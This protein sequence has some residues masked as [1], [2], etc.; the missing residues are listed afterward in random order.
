MEN[1]YYLIMC[2][3]NAAPECNQLYHHHLKK[4]N[5]IDV[6][7]NGKQMTIAKSIKSTYSQACNFERDII[8][9]YIEN[10]R[11]EIKKL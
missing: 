11:P 3:L 1:G 8:R 9:A 4:D 10:N 6:S 2:D 5:I 7:F